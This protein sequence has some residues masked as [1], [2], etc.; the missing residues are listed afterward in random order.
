MHSTNQKHI[1]PI[2]SKG[3]DISDEEK[4][5]LSELDQDIVAPKKVDLFIQAWINV[6]N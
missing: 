2:L 5:L 1:D 6:A 3:E 4:L